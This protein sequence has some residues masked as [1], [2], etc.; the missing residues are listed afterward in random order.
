MVRSVR[1]ELEITTC[2]GSF[3][4]H[5]SRRGTWRPTSDR[6]TKTTAMD[7]AMSMKNALLPPTP[8]AHSPAYELM[9]P[10]MRPNATAVPTPVAR[11]VVG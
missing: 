6:Q 3:R 10:P 9:T 8:S 7:A 2:D 11:T 4:V 5:R 1:L